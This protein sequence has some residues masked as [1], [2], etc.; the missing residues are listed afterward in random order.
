MMEK[1][2]GDMTFLFVFMFSFE[3]SS[4]FL[5]PPHRSDVFPF[6]VSSVERNL[7]NK[8]PSAV[9]MCKLKMEQYA[10]FRAI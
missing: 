2:D 5:I 4:S 7:K 9:F 8:T 6:F 3:E 1:R 10:G